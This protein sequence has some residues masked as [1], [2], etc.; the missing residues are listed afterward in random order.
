MGEVFLCVLPRCA[1]GRAGF[2]FQGQRPPSVPPE[3]RPALRAALRIPHAEP[4]HVVR[5]LLM[6]GRS[7]K[8]PESE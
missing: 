7:Q 6:T 2:G 1:R 4:S 3:A 5:C 8:V